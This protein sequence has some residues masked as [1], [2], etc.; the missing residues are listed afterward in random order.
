[1]GK[2]CDCYHSHHGSSGVVVVEMTVTTVIIVCRRQT[3]YSHRG[4]SVGIWRGHSRSSS[5]SDDGYHSHH[6]NV[7]KG[8]NRAIGMCDANGASRI[9][10]D[11]SFRSVATTTGG[12]E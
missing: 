6:G 8:G 3:S 4:S 11:V 5:G 2:R 10:R 7:G 12:L 9:D 1:M